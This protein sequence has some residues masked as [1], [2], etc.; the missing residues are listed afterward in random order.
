[1][2]T[3]KTYAIGVDLG[4]TN[5]VFG[6]VDAQGTIVAQ[7]SIKTQAYKTA[8][9]FVEAGVAC[10][11]PLIEQVGGIANLAGMGIGA[12]N[13]NYYSGAIETA[14]NIA[15][16]H[17]TVVP[18]AQMFSEKLRS[19]LKF[20]EFSTRYKDVYDMYY[21]SGNMDKESLM[22]CF[23]TYILDDSG[24]RENTMDDIVKRISMVFSN[25]RYV[26]RLDTSDKRWLDDDIQIVT[27]TI[28]DFLKSL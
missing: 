3:Q 15:W 5:T 14:P 27:G 2:K 20:G 8:E 26:N 17:D 11:R 12:P 24:M 22:K 10:L 18:L 9:A 23:H 6:I 16:A 1:M 28:L 7:D 19:L 21:H 25:R 13:A 4:G